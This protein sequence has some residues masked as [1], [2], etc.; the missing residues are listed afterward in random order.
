MKV[1]RHGKAAIIS[2]TDYVKILKE[3]ANDKYRLLVQIARYTGERWGAIVQMRVADAYGPDGAPR[4]KLTFRA[5]TR[6]ASPDG[7]RETRQVP[8]HPQLVVELKAYKPL[9]ESEWL[10]PSRFSES[11]LSFDAADDFWRGCLDRAGLSGR[12]ISTHSTRR[13]MISKLANAGMGAPLIKAI[14]G[15]KDM[16]ALQRYIEIDDDR[17]KAAI[18]L[19]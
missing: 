6:K 5:G 1:Q 14:T 4:S 19:L 8:T 10:F 3:I 2:D 9:I 15:H 7:E 13:S 11:H 17:I 12:G 18:A 16:K